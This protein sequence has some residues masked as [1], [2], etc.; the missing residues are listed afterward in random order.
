MPS[1]PPWLL[2]T[3]HRLTHGSLTTLLCVVFTVTISPVS[4]VRKLS[5][6]VIQLHGSAVMERG[7]EPRGPGSRAL[8]LIHR[9]LSMQEAWEWGCGGG[10]QCRKLPLA[11]P[12]PAFHPAL[13]DLIALYSNLQPSISIAVTP[14]RP[15]PSPDRPKIPPHLEQPPSSLP[16]TQHPILPLVTPIPPHL[17]LSPLALHLYTHPPSPQ[18]FPSGSGSVSSSSRTCLPAGAEPGRDHQAGDRELGLKVPSRS[19]AHPLG[20]QLPACASRGTSATAVFYEFVGAETCRRPQLSEPRKS[21]PS[22]GYGLPRQLGPRVPQVRPVLGGPCPRAH[23]PQPP[24]AGRGKGDLGKFDKLLPPP[25]SRPPGER[26]DRR[27]ML[28]PQEPHPAATEP[29]GH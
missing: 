26:P 12:S 23:L 10:S 6:G 25:P 4:Q 5:N 28:V 2:S 27:S 19:L 20:R 15:P 17:H 21:L 24:W 13:R 3:L 14:I 8:A 16:P 9:S 18:P 1:E 22:P 29:P 11:T 7:L